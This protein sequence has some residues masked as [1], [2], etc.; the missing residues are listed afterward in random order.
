[1]RANSFRLSWPLYA[2]MLVAGAAAVVASASTLSTLAR[3]AGWQGWTPWL[4]PAALDIGGSAG[5]WCWLRPGVPDQA[6]RF[7]RVVALAGAGGSLVGNAAGHLMA[8][9][10]LLPGPVLVVIVGAI[11]AAVL[12]ALAHLAA[13]LALTTPD[14]AEHNELAEDQDETEPEEQDD[15]PP[16]EANPRDAVLALI[17]QHPVTIAGLAKA[18]GRSRSTVIG[19]LTALTEAGL[20]HRDD[21]KRYHAVTRPHLISSKAVS[22]IVQETR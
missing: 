13:L 11:P 6:R 8:T 4:L 9:G 3:A 12:V 22:G 14:G 10:Y 7:G 1:M 20:I 16:D 2:G 21:A 18:T 5:G 15:A 17:R 19:H